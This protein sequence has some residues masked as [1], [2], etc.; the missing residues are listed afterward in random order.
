[1]PPRPAYSLVKLSQLVGSEV[2]WLPG[3]LN[4]LVSKDGRMFSMCRW[5][6]PRFIWLDEP[7]PLKQMPSRNG[8]G[9]ICYSLRRNGKNVTLYAHQAVLLAFVGPC[10]AGHE[11]SHFN[12]IPADNRLENLAWE[13]RKQNH[14]RKKLNG[15]E[16]IGERN[17][18]HKFTTQTVRTILADLNRGMT[19]IEVA[20]KYKRPRSSI[21]DMKSG[22]SWS[23]LSNPNWPF[24]KE[25][26]A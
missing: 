23:H 19:P 21:Q 9:Y 3:Y 22:L 20:R 18:A 14:F 1:M 10:P 5:F 16:V 8:H 6:I 26:S 12:D 13:T 17:P 25:K 7:H 11:S 4:Y 2:K 15:R 24:P